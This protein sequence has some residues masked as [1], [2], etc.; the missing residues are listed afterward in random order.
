MQLQPASEST[1]HESLLHMDMMLLPSHPPPCCDPLIFNTSNAA[2]FK[3][4]RATLPP[5]IRIQ[6]STLSQPEQTKPP[7]A[8]VPLSHLGKLPLSLGELLSLRVTGIHQ[9][10]SWKPKRRRRKK[11]KDVFDKVSS[12]FGLSLQ[13]PMLTEKA[14]QPA[15]TSKTT[16]SHPCP[17]AISQAINGPK[18]PLWSD[19]DFG[20]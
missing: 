18:S 11:K 14:F 19:A 5:Q 15:V 10:P 17:P 8:S 4:H 2:V 1:L 7:A 3:E 9:L 16:N 13:S 6:H 12:S 20:S